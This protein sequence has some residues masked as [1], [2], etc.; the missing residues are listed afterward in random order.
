[1]AK[2]VANSG[3]PG[4]PPE[5]ASPACFFIFFVLY[6]EMPAFFCFYTVFHGF[7]CPFYGWPLSAL[8]RGWSGRQRQ[9]IPENRTGEGHGKFF[10]LRLLLFKKKL[11]FLQ[12][13]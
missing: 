10:S 4:G 13:S 12:P 3:G 5:L 7:I 6:R 8:Y 1:M 2:H 11:L 9:K